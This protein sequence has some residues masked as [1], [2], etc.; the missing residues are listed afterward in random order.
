[1]GEPCTVGA[2]PLCEAVDGRARLLDGAARRQVRGLLWQTGPLFWSWMLYRL[3]RRTM[4]LYEVALSGE[5]VTPDVHERADETAA[6]SLTTLRR[7]YIR[8]AD[9]L[10]ASTT[11]TG[12]YPTEESP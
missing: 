3:R 2:N 8:A 9:W 4:N 6:A 11:R 12:P 7:L 5:P 10:R 1:M